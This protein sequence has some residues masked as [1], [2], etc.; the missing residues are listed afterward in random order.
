[1][2]EAISFDLWDTVIHDDSDEP[3]R[4]ARGLRSKR[5]ERRH[6]V[7]EALAAQAPIDE[8]AVGQAYDVAEAAFNNVWKK[9]FI[10][11]TVRERLEVLLTGLRRTLPAPELDRIIDAHEGMELEVAP[12]PIAGADVALAA[13][14]DR[15]RLAV[16]SDA[17][18]SPGRCLRQWLEAH[19]LLR[20]FSAFA[21][22][23]EVGHSKPHRSM[24]DSVAE[25][26]GIELRHMVHIGDRDHNDVK[27]SQAV[28]M[29][30]IL[31][32]ATRASDAATTSADAICN[33]YA[34]LPRV[35]A[36]LA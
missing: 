3:K 36:A 25:Q 17:I 16:V 23:D 30:A 20:Y 22:S 19:G 15:Y 26:L 18:V 24:F 21:F 7:W 6:L 32:T 33:S 1:M 14:A 31:F 28:G 12:D 4:A 2:L 29:R 11:W 10:T 34:E 13:L 35:I 8:A 27:G 5:D 9:H